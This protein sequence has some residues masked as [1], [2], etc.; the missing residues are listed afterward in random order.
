MH[1][2]VKS[3]GQ[4]RIFSDNSNKQ[5]RIPQGILNFFLKQKITFSNATLHIQRNKIANFIV[6]E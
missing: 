2:Q 3:V 5:N 4:Q 1:I 6:N